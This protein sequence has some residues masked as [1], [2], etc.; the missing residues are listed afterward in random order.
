MGT[1]INFRIIL[2]IFLSSSG[3]IFPFSFFLQRKQENIPFINLKYYNRTYPD[4]IL[5]KLN[6]NLLNEEGKFLREFI[7][8][9]LM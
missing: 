2:S 7:R 1:L 4:Y 5:Q 3:P 6:W 9:N 8:R